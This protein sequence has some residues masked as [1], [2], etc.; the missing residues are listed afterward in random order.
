MATT[1]SD[2]C[3]L[4]TGVFRE[5]STVARQG[6]G[7]TEFAAATTDDTVGVGIAIALGLR[8]VPTLP[9]TVLA[10]AISRGRL[11]GAG[12]FPATVRIALTG[13]AIVGL[14]TD[15]WVALRGFT[16]DFCTGPAAAPDTFAGI[17]P[18]GGFPLF[19]GLAGYDLAL[20]IGAPAFG[21]GPIVGGTL[22]VTAHP[23]IVAG[24][25]GPVA[26]AGVVKRLTGDFVASIGG[27]IAVPLAVGFADAVSFALVFGAQTTPDAALVT[28]AGLAVFGFEARPGLTAGLRIDFVAFTVDAPA[29]GWF[30]FDGATVHVAI[31]VHD[32]CARGQTGPGAV[33]VD[34]KGLTGNL[35][36]T[37]RAGACPLGAGP[38]AIF[39]AGAGIAAVI[40]ISG[41]PRLTRLG[42]S[43]LSTLPLTFVATAGITAVPCG[44]GVTGLAFVAGK[45]GTAPLPIAVTNTG[46]AA[47]TI[48][49]FAFDALSRWFG[50]VGDVAAAE[51]TEARK[52]PE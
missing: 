21:H 26:L 38:T 18:I 19:A 29:F 23:V 52:D 17:T 45:G 37:R 8:V 16:A 5:K 4:K 44:H 10:D 2:L 49:G 39:F 31:I 32:F 25:A 13:L 11:H 34:V 22:L 42:A 33:A 51:T 6:L 43:D 36:T 20:A 41:V 24:D 30:F 7:P 15:P 28:L 40:G 3:V 27:S 9:V 50:I 46:I 47:W 1:V 14:E 12:A 35:F 48:T